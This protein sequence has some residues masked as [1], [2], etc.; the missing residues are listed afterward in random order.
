MHSMKE[1]SL[2]RHG[3]LGNL[4]HSLTERFCISFGGVAMLVMSTWFGTGQGEALSLGG[5]LIGTEAATAVSL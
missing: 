1:H 5:R 2:I 3:G 4:G